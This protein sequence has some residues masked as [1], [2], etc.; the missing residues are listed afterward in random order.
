MYACWSA[1]VYVR[2]LTCRCLCLKIMFHVMTSQ[3]RGNQRNNV[4]TLSCHMCFFS[5][6]LPY[7]TFT[8]NVTHT[9]THYHM[10]IN[11]NNTHTHTHG[12]AN[13]QLLSILL[14]IKYLFSCKYCN[15]PKKMSILAQHYVLLFQFLAKIFFVFGEGDGEGRA[16]RIEDYKR[17]QDVH[18]LG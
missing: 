10:N 13:F 12:I 2:E 9:F 7:R 18:C 3:K 5:K 8:L 14:S 17:K 11:S 16:C 6:H 15:V 4:S 1:D